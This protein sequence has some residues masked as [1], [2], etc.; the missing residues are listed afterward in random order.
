MNALLQFTKVQ[1]AVIQLSATNPP[2]RLILAYRD[3]ATLF[4]LI[5]KPSIVR[6]G[7]DSREEAVG[8]DDAVLDKVAGPRRANE[9][10]NNP[11][12]PRQLYSGGDRAPERSR[13]PSLRSW[14]RG[15]VQFAFA[16]ALC[17]F[18]S[19]NVLCATAR[20]V[21]AGSI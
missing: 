4:A 15:I 13:F 3:E 5:A 10:E 16:A 11:L 12:E 8:T 1:Y 18:Y 6:L 21:L 2:E 17:I 19:R 20:A 9:R 14:G 7:F